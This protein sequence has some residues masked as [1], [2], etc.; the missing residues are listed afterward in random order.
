MKGLTSLSRMAAVILLF[1]IVLQT[2]GSS[3]KEE[4]EEEAIF[5][6]QFAL[7]IPGGTDNPDRVHDLAR[8]HGFQN[9]GQI[10]GIHDHFLF[11]HHEL[12]HRSR[13]RSHFHHRILRNESSVKWFQQQKEKKRWKRDLQHDYLRFP[14]PL[15]PKQWY[16]NRGAADGSDMNVRPAW[17]M[18]YTGK[19]VVVTILDDGIQLNHP[20][21]KANYD[22]L[23]SIDINDDDDDPTPQDNNDNK[24]GTRCAGEVAAEAF[25]NI[26][27]VGVAFNASIGGVRMLDGMVNDAVEAKALSLNPNHVDI[28][29]ASWG[30]EDDGKTVDGPGPLAKKAF[31]NGVKKGRQGKG[32]IFI[33]AS[34]NGGRK[35]DNCNCDGYTNSIYTLSISSATQGGRKPW[36]LEECSSTLASTYSSGTPNHDASIAT[37]DQDARLRKDKMCTTAHTGTSASAPIAAGVCALTLEANRNLTWRDM[38]HIVVITSNPSPLMLESGWM[39]N[40][41]GRKYSHKFGYGL[42]DAA[43]MVNVAKIWKGVGKQVIC[44]T[45][46]QI[47]N[48]PISPNPEQVTR[49]TMETKS[50]SGTAKQI[51]YLEH[52][53]CKI[54][55]EF[56]PRGA[57]HVVLTSPSGTKSSLLL[58]RPK[59]RSSSTFENWPFLSVHFWGES[60]NGTWT[61]EINRNPSV[62]PPAGRQAN[63]ILKKWK[64][65]FY[66][67]KESPLNKISSNEIKANTGKTT[68]SEENKAFPTG[69]HSTHV[70]SEVHVV[71]QTI[72]HLQQIIGPDGCSIECKGGCSEDKS[73]CHECKNYRFDKYCVAECPKNT[74]PTVEKRCQQCDKVCENCFGPLAKQCLSCSPGYSLVSDI[75]E[76]VVHCPSRYRLQRETNECLPCPENCATCSTLLSGSDETINRKKR[77]DSE[78]ICTSC[79][80]GLVLFTEEDICL[81]S[82]PAGFYKDPNSAIC[83]A[84][85]EDCAT[86]I[87]PL[88][89]QCS[90][91][92]EGT[93]F[94]ER[95]CR[96]VC[97]LG[98]RPNSLIH[99]CVPC[100]K[101]CERCSEDHECLKCMDEWQLDHALDLCRPT[102]NFGC[103]RNEYSDASGKCSKCHESCETCDGRSGEHCLSCKDDHHLHISTCV[104]QCPPSTFPAA[105][106]ECLHCPHACQECSDVEHCHKCQDSYFL[107]ADETSCHASCLP[108]EHQVDGRCQECHKSC[109]TCNGFDAYH[110]LSCS[111]GQVLSNGQCVSKCP[112]GFYDDNKVCVPCY[113]SCLSCFGPGPEKCMSCPRGMKLTGDVCLSCE[114]GK[115]YDLSSSKCEFC[116]QDC[117]TCHGPRETD[118]TSCSESLVL[119]PWNKTCVPCC[120]RVNQDQCCQCDTQE[121][122]CSSPTTGNGT[123]KRSFREELRVHSPRSA[124]VLFTLVTVLVFAIL[125]FLRVARRQKRRFLKNRRKAKDLLRKLPLRKHPNESDEDDELLLNNVSESQT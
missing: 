83:N 43:A 74:F 34:G 105:N 50:C 117:R 42:M 78:A 118:C 121:H 101:G 122:R 18:G 97:P 26:C 40:G 4:D 9:L 39:E 93:F 84:C 64:L 110:C 120:T 52:V 96:S 8:Q 69:Y 62:V 23:A 54:S 1:F 15:F 13:E 12:D 107:S 114:R 100:A 36:Y 86:C 48:A 6:N 109:E 60:A 29:S 89:T 37:V 41:V 102:E 87:G 85:H 51:G 31:V 94:F 38:Q 98:S 124:F 5:H 2:A 33:W 77:H 46:E 30:P 3:N 66:G 57:L 7:H 19:R 35:T 80:E 25:N 59:D 106:K 81:D 73:I 44:E 123:K 63:G 32:S 56:H 116:H 45:E 58:P 76:C 16:L 68:Q 79:R 17:E 108:G 90:L 125:L 88:A 53:Q 67:T 72:L 61:L 10:G 27:G 119:D 28:Y 20:D 71:N 91:C 112:T 103:S 104:D 95:Q 21:L 92:K 75:S 14:D 82:C 65:F 113:S 111:D 99:E 22:P 115:Y 70:S 55:L 11:R 24:H 47:P 49:V